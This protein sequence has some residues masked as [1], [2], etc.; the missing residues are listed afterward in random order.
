M[1]VAALTPSIDYAEDGVTVNF[2]V[3]FRYRDPSHLKASREAADGTV[4][5]LAYGTD[6]SAT[7]G[8]SDAGGTL[9]VNAAAAVG[10]TLSIWRETPRQQD[11]DYITTGAFKADTHEATL[12]ENVMM[13]QEVDREIARAPKVPRGEVAA[14]LPG[15][16]ERKGKYLAFDATGKPVPSVGTGGDD[17]FRADMA[18][19][20]G[21]A[22]VGVD[23]GAGGSI[24]VSLQAFINKLLSSTGA[25]IVG[26]IQAGAGAVLRS[27]LDKLREASVSVVDFGAVADGVTDDA[28]AIQAA[29]DFVGGLGGGR[30]LI[31]R[32]SY[33]V[34][35]TI[36]IPSN[37]HVSG[38]GMLATE[39]IA[40][41][42]LA[43][44]N[45]VFTNS[46]NDGL[47]RTTY[48]ENIR[49]SDMTIDGNG[50]NRTGGIV[51][52]VGN[53]ITLSTVRHSQIKRVR[54]I[55]GALH[56]I[57]IKASV[58]FDDGTY[59]GQ[60]AGPSEHIDIIGC[61][62]EDTYYDDGITVHNSGHIHIRNCHVTYDR[63]TY[64]EPNG[65][66]YGIEADEGSYNVQV[67]NCFA[68]GW[69]RGFVAK[70]HATTHGAQGVLF[71]SCYSYANTQGFWIY[72]Q[73]GGV[74]TPNNRDVVVRDCT[75]DSPATHS[76]FVSGVNDGRLIEVTQTKRVAIENLTIIDPGT[77]HIHITGAETKDVLV[78]GVHLFGAMSAP[79]GSTY[80]QALI[81]VRGGLDNAKVRIE[82]VSAEDAQPKPLVWIEDG[83]SQIVVDGVQGAGTNSAQG[84]VRCSST[85]NLRL[86]LRNIDNLGGYGGLVNDLNTAALYD[87]YYTQEMGHLI[88]TT[89]PSGSPLG[90]VAAPNGA[91][92]FGRT[93]GNA[94]KKSS[95]TDG[96]T[97]GWVAY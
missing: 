50:H 93:S 29:I 97:D 40:L 30:V 28:P 3:P 89:I 33:A 41:T 32:G 59:A 27:V 58:Y 51:Q 18:A 68:S 35:A 55:N 80:E 47:S 72:H 76:G 84:V 38:D 42:T 52:G 96:G 16:D 56:G 69:M 17:G 25:A 94:Y 43:R 15:A 39:I 5:L 66:Q 82:D 12:D 26:F 67:Q 9:T 57:D 24:F 65:W 6:Y 90:V 70:G 31:P 75:I 60:P 88:T 54:S 87:Y 37:V 10:V 83:N 8:D 74:G 13:L 49:I 4:T 20:G 1:T 81:E 21:G 34:N 86:A 2:P 78:R 48:N 44:D 85:A 61:I 46:L 36:T 73:T 11:S 91:R 63:A 19:S 14:D 77:G 92:C 64:G 53:N 95:G 23:D 71:Q 62:A 45:D 79:V 22:L 7:A